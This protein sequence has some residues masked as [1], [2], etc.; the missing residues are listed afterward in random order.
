MGWVKKE[1]IKDDVILDELKKTFPDKF[2]LLRAVSR[3]C[4]GSVYEYLSDYIRDYY[5]VTLWQCDRVSKCLAEH[6]GIKKFYN[7]K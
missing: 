6:L 3:N 4:C 7:Y 2:S 1:T 5:E